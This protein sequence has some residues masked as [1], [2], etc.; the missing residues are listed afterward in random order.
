MPAKEVSEA[1]AVGYR[2][3]VAVLVVVMMAAAAAPPA[4]AHH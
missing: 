1:W 2:G 4:A 3:A